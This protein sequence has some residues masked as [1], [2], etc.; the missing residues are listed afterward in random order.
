MAPGFWKKLKNFA[1]KV[2][3]AIKKGA[4]YVKDKVIPA[5]GNVI[6]KVAQAAPGIIDAVSGAVGP[7]KV[8]DAMHMAGNIIG[9]VNDGFG[10]YAPVASQVAGA[11]AGK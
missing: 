6:K 10:R 1:S 4:A 9:K 11:I 8:S 5:A 3:N 2:G 7:G